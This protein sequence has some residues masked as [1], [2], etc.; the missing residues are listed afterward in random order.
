MRRLFISDLHLQDER[1]DITRAFCYFLDQIAPGADELYL[2]GDIFELWIG[3]DYQSD[4]FADICPRL[5]ALRTTGTR[6]YL[7]HGNRDF[8]LGASAAKQLSAE[9]IPGSLIIALP[10]GKTLLMHGDELC[11]DDLEYQTFRKQ[12]RSAVWQ[13]QF[14]AQPLEQRLVTARELRK[15]SRDAN[16]GKADYI[17]DV[18]S[19]TV[20]QIMQQQDVDLLI[21]GHTHR[22]QIHHQQKDETGG[23]RVVLGD[24]HTD[25][26]YILS[27]E[28]RFELVNF[29]PV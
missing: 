14:L 24:W 5:A 27:D 1:S 3:D 4:L 22:P 21:H 15:T 29:H 13:Q 6:I 2:L 16:A 19:D 20:A 8:L 28:E 23:I 7:Q 11:T 26:W 25:G 10:Q 17:M 12:L 18:N 9:L